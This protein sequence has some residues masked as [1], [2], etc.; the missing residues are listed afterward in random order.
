MIPTV[1]ASL[2]S[3]AATPSGASRLFDA[4]KGAVQGGVDRHIGDINLD[5]MGRQSQGFLSTVFGERLAGLINWLAR[6]AGIKESSASSLMNVAS[7]VVM[8]TLGKTIQQKGLDA[9]QL[10]Q[11]LA[12]QSGWLSRLLP[13]GIGE[14]PGMRTLSDLGDRAAEAGRTAVEAGRRVGAAVDRGAREAVRPVRQGAPLL[15]ALAP[16]ALLLLAIP[17]LMWFLRGSPETVQPENMAAVERAP[18]ERVAARPPAVDAPERIRPETTAAP[19]LTPTSLELS[20]LKLPGGAILQ[21]PESSFL[22]TIYKYLSDATATSS[23]QFVFDDLQF[24]DT[25][26]RERPDT[27][28]AVANLTQLILAFPSV[29]LRIEGHTDASGD[30]AADEKRSLARAES[31]KALL[32]KAGVPGSRITTAGLGSEH[33]VASNDTADG[34]AKNRRIELSLSKSA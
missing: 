3:Q 23:R 8:S 5:A 20:D 34:R 29:K 1:L 33:P 17:L 25:T 26:I 14:V 6:F 13:A 30:A 9:T 11:L 4:V 32:V 19:V 27:D 12:S 24:D 16:L 2:T 28:K 31:L 18:V 21:L 22:T 15:S 10:G 7:S